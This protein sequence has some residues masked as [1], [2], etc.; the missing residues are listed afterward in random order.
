LHGN[1]ESKLAAGSSG[2][3]RE[4]LAMVDS[5][6]SAEVDWNDGQLILLLFQD[7]TNYAI[8]SSWQGHE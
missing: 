8:F 1:P 4:S 5:P 3:I 7:E 6:L 2:A